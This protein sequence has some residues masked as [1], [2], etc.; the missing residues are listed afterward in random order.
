[1]TKI[2][3]LIT[4]E[5]ASVFRYVKF[6]FFIKKI[7]KGVKLWGRITM[8]GPENISIGD[9]VTINEGAFLNG[10]AELIIGDYVRLSSF[11]QLHTG[12][13]DL[14]ENYKG[15]QHYSKKIILEEGVWICAGAIVNPGIRI[16]KGAVIAPGS[17]ITKD[18]P[19]FQL[20]GVFQLKK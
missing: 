18:V 14:S 11:C 1:M 4:R 16:G 2:I 19:M 20:W 15:R 13:L 8:V 10:T 5:L 6:W 12:G 17:V 3:F 9:N 7:G